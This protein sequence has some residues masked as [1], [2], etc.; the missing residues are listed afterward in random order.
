MLKNPR[1]A[2]SLGPYIGKAGKVMEKR[3][4]DNFSKAGY[5]LTLHHWIV[6][7][8]LW[9]K[10][11]QNQKT[12]CDYAGWNKTMITRTIDSLEAQNY[13]I[14]VPDKEDRR[15][16]LIYLTHKGKT[17]QDELGTIMIQS[18]DEATANIAQEDLETC[19]MVL[20]KIFLNL[21]EEEH[22]TQF[23]PDSIK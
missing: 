21:A 11:G 12:L 10:D 22:I 19:K 8:H 2:N 15:N 5:E 6:M 14:R 17:A 20:Q 16:K 18:L 23:S 13:V 1:L 7:V 9:I 4:N 3:V